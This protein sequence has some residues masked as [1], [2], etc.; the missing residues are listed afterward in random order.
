MKH[1]GTLLGLFLP[2]CDADKT[3]SLLFRRYAH[4]FLTGQEASLSVFRCS[5]TYLI[6]S[7][8]IKVFIFL[9]S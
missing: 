8:S 5:N 9:K 6:V 4:N 7:N 1:F 2:E 3:P